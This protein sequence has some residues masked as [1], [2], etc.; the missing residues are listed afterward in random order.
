MK[1]L[2]MTTPGEKVIVGV[3]GGAD[4]V[5]LFSVLLALREELGVS[6]EAV[7][8]NHCLRDSAAAD[9]HFVRELCSKKGVV[10]HTYSVDVHAR[11][12]SEGVSTEEAGR[13][14]RYEC[15]AD[16][17]KK[18]G[19]GKLAVA[20]HKNDQAETIL[21]HLSRGSGVSGLTGIRPVRDHVIRPLL[22]LDREQVEMYLSESGQNYVTDETNAS[23]DYSRN[24]VRH[25]VLPVLEEVCPGA[26]QHI[27]AAGERM[28][29][30][31]DYLQL[32]IRDAAHRCADMTGYDTGCVRLSCMELSGLHSYLQ[33]EVIREC[34]FMLA[35]SKKD[36]SR[37]H[38]EAVCGLVGLQVGRK[39]E[40]PYGIEVQ[41][42][43]ETL[44]FI[45][46]E[47]GTSQTEETEAF[48][49][50]LE[51]EIPETGAEVRLP[52]GKKMRLRTFVY[53]PEDEI[54]T[55]TYTKWL[56]YD[57]IGRTIEIRTPREDDFFYFNYKNKKYVKD[58]MVNE[59]IPMAERGK[60]I[61]VADGNHM[62]YFVG[63]RIS[64]GALI[65]ET[66]RKILE[67]TV[68]GG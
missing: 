27:A 40:L 4:S 21:F 58:Y 59:K 65:D 61:L 22:C 10:L 57:K 38:V 11:A 37:V 20:H 15:F 9:E 33:T 49:E 1:K 42:S 47:A 35:D 66:T 12:K 48:C 8:V 68:T 5:C 23:A 56:D 24:R 30:V 31:S 53:N 17:M 36:I 14:A 51:G 16:A 18:S 45:K 44:I 39:V 64:N 50:R 55:K 52:G 34:I 3:S 43:Y 60:C 19:A 67:I 13:N 26:S 2:H 46:K 41:K 6:V 62:L 54:P 63:K 25:E 29:E 7:H 32:Q 28:T